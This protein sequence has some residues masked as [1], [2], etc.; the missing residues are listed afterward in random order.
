MGS[1]SLG[2]Q[3]RTHDRRR[4]RQLDEF[5]SLGRGSM[6]EI[7]TGQLSAAGDLSENLGRTV[8]REARMSAVYGF[9]RARVSTCPRFGAPW[10]MS[11]PFLNQ[12]NQDGDMAQFLGA[13]W[14]VS[15]RCKQRT[16]RHQG[17]PYRTDVDSRSICRHSR[18]F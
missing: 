17:L 5:A 3:S 10:Q 8:L 6:G 14:V 16:L 7:G 15:G 1:H 2:H 4:C 9:R 11:T 18:H 13:P 12:R